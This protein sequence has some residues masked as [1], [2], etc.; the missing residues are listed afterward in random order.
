[1][2]NNFLI[3]TLHYSR[4]CFLRTLSLNNSHIYICF[5]SPLY[6]GVLYI[7]HKQCYDRLINR[8]KTSLTYVVLTSQAILY[9]VLS[10]LSLPLFISK[11]TFNHFSVRV[12]CISFILPIL[13]LFLCGLK[14]L[15]SKI[16][17][18][19]LKILL[20]KTSHSI[21]QPTVV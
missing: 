17:L 16:R 5:F 15:K 9:N 8:F 4:H 14:F 6:N 19:W 2:A 7:K 3:L 1:M 11:Y 18:R 12:M 20:L 10:N 13:Q 21:R